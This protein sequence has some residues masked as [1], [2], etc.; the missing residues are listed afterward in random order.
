M[1]ILRGQDKTVLNSEVNCKSLSILDGGE[2]SYTLGV[3][4]LSKI[5]EMALDFMIQ[6]GSLFLLNRECVSLPH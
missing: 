3:P 2:A 1:N 6:C 4:R 5:S